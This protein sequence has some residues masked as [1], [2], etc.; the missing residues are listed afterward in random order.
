M[1]QGM[2]TVQ[3]LLNELTKYAARMI[4]LLDVYTFHKW[5]I[6]ALHNT[7][8]NEVLKKGYTAEFSTIEKIFET[9]Q[10]IED[11]SRYH[12]R[13]QHMGNTSLT[14]G[15]TRAT[16]SRP[17]QTADASKPAVATRSS[18]AANTEARMP[19]TKPHV[20]YKLVQ[21]LVQANGSSTKPSSQQKQMTCPLD[22]TSVTSTA[23]CFECG[24]AG[25]LR[26]N[27]VHLKTM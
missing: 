22:H 8:H 19:P 21:K 17:E 7:L 20:G 24:Q 26:T 12:I 18:A 9:A 27:C 2:K 13:M 3:D 16:W 15:T 5:F 23:A 4:H 14:A 11:V 6:S 25:H 10:M 1:F